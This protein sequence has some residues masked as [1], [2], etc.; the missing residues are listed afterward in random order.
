MSS[1]MATRGW[2]S[3]VFA[4]CSAVRCGARGTTYQSGET[5]YYGSCH[6]CRRLVPNDAS[7]S[8]RAV[9]TRDIEGS[10]EGPPFVQKQI[11]RSE[12]IAKT[13]PTTSI[14]IISSGSI[15]GRP[16]VERASHR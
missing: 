14:R 7:G 13:Y 1:R 2:S 8:M 16:I 10:L 5:R 15:D 3:V 12:R 4:L 9:V 6:A 11:S